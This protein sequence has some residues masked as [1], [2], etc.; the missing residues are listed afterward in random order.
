MKYFLDSI[1]TL[2]YWKYA[3]FSAEA[4]A[5]ILTVVGTLY[6]FVELLDTFK[7]YKKDDYHSYA[8]LIMLGIS[9]VYVLLNR[10]PVSRVRYKAPKKD[11]TFEVLI[12]DLFEMPGEII[13][14]SNSTFDT[15]IA[16][17]LISSESLQGQFALKVF[18]GQTAEI[19]RQIEA[20]LSG[21]SFTVNN[22]RPGKKK[23]YPIGTVAR[24]DANGKHFYLLA[25]AHM[26]PTR[27]AYSDPRILDEAL[28]GLWKNMAAKGERGDI[29]MPLVGT[30][31]GRVAIPRKKIVEKI[32]QSFADASQQTIFS[33]KLT[34]VSRPE[35]AARFSLN[36]FQIRDYL[37][38]SLHI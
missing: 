23:E 24:I 13:I 7:I 14:S 15:D 9:I 1:R 4:V 25:M 31:R 8:L 33:N 20:S 3:L 11:L 6:L 19:D 2:S 18:N 30:G 32:A 21:E 34:I 10:R 35:D 27:N 38:Q 37:S 17:G 26:M 28:E 36:L 5:K 29:A 12:G 22:T 16:S